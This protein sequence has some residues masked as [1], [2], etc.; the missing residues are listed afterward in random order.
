MN[1]DTLSSTIQSTSP[2]TMDCGTRVPV[3]RPDMLGF[4]IRFEHVQRVGTGGMCDVF[5]SFDRTRDCWVALKRLRSDRAK[6]CGDPEQFLTEAN[7]MRDVASKC[8]PRL[9]DIFPQRLFEPYFSMQWIEGFDLS[10]VLSGLHRLPES[11]DDNFPLHRLVNIVLRILDALAHSHRRGWLHLDIKPENIMLEDSR[12]W[13]IDW[14]CATRMAAETS[15][16]CKSAAIS[17]DR[18]QPNLL[19]DERR[20]VFGTPLYMSPEQLKDRCS[21]DQR[22]DL[23]ALGAV[24][25]D[26]VALTTLI[27]GKTVDEVVQYT[28]SGRF[29]EPSEVGIRK[30]IPSQLE[31][32]VMKAVAV[33]PQDR[34]QSADAFANAL[35]LACPEAVD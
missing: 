31:D 33:D 8:V 34:F 28:L 16:E 23:F 12:T 13:L 18:C 25:Y 14:G 6:R 20:S 19:P 21:V 29:V 15:A 9:H 1:A 5:R 11:L 24:L 17:G 4:D 35:K 27:R 7:V 3:G 32:V 2:F 30:S 10:R 26:C 22:S